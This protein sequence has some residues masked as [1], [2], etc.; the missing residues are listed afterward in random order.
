MHS[1]NLRR[2]LTLDTIPH[3]MDDLSQQ[4]T[5]S[6]GTLFFAFLIFDIFLFENNRFNYLESPSIIECARKAKSGVVAGTR[7]VDGVPNA[8]KTKG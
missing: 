6:Q 2:A 5:N 4:R 1:L 8:V 7:G 3:A